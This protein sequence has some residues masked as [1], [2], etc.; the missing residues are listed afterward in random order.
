MTLDQ[1]R[2]LCAKFLLQS[3]CVSSKLQR[4]K[5][6]LMRF[7]DGFVPDFP[8]HDVHSARDRGFPLNRSLNA[9]FGQELDKS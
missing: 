7:R 9:A 6:Q 8:I 4:L 3:L 5:R 1:G 2:Y